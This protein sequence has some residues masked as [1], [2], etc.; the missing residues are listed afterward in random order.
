MHPSL[1]EGLFIAITLFTLTDVSVQTSYVRVI[2]HSVGIGI[3][4]FVLYRIL[5]SFTDE[6]QARYHYEMDG[7]IMTDGID[8]VCL[9]N[10]LQ[11]W[12]KGHAFAIK[13][14]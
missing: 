14:T 4:L 3:I 5:E 2:L 1:L 9:H 6:I 7:K 11:N 8:E 10:T 13:I 12:Q